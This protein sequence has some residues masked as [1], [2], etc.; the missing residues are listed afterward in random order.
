VALGRLNGVMN[1]YKTTQRDT[2]LPRPKV[3]HRLGV[4]LSGH[5]LVF[6]FVVLITRVICA[7]LG[8]DTAVLL[9]DI[10]TQEELVW[11]TYP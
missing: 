10:Q 5:A 2:D 1:P 9:I 3:T 6:L 8:Y 4:W 11:P 7:S